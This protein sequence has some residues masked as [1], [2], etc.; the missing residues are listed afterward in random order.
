MLYWILKAFCRFLFLTRIIRVKYLHRELVPQSGP[1]MLAC[2]HYSR[3]DMAF[4]VQLTGQKVH[5]MAIAEYFRF[6]PIAVVLRQLGAFPVQWNGFNRGSLDVA[7]KLLQSSK[8]VGIFVIGHRDKRNLKATAKGGCAR[9]AVDS[10]TDPTIVP[11]AICCRR[12]PSKWL[13][14]SIDVSICCGEPIHPSEY[15]NDEAMITDTLSNRLSQA[16]AECPGGPAALFYFY[17]KKLI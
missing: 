2:S 1:V 4:V 11:V 12:W 5:V 7:A 16:K 15:G 10:Q 14:L 3:M 17:A 9:I 13:P 6:R 8:T